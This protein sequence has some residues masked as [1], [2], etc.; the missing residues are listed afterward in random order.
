M[1]SA[2]A[3]VSVRLQPVQKKRLPENGLS[4]WQQLKDF[5]PLSRETVRLREIEGKFPRR[6]R[7]TEHCT[8]WDN[9]E[10]HRWLADPI[11]YRAD[12]SEK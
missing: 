1:E 6:I 10:I 9:A 3:A 5:V 8:L 7:L 11:G 4:R 2:V 12:G